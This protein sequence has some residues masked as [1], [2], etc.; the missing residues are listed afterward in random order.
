MTTQRRRWWLRFLWQ[1]FDVV[2]RRRTARAPPPPP[3]PSLPPRCVRGDDDVDRLNSA[4]E[5]LVQLLGRQLKL[6]ESAVDLVNHEHRA[7]ALAGVRW[8]WVSW[9]PQQ[10]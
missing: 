7:H 10:K 9:V 2:S 1:Y 8:S 6:K 3:S 4:A 5:G